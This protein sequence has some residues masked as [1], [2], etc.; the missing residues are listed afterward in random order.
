LRY[1][2]CD[3]LRVLS[4]AGRAAFVSRAAVTACF[5]GLL[6]VRCTTGML[7]CLDRE[8]RIAFILGAMFGLSHLVGADALGITPENFRIRLHRARNEHPCRCHKKT[9]GFVERGLV[10]PARL[11]FTREH[12][13]R[14]D[15][16]IRRDADEAMQTFDD[17]HERVFRAHPLQA[18]DSRVVDEILGDETLNRFFDLS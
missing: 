9:R 15:E 2:I 14:V 1:W 13:E 5:E 10:D 3:E 4:G 11:V 16:L 18:S 12:R 6:R 7:I 17:L 8:Q